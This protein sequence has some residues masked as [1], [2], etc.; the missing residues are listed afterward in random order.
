MVARC[1][2]RNLSLGFAPHSGEYP[3]ESDHHR[4]NYPEAG[5]RYSDQFEDDGHAFLISSRW[6]S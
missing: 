5:Y 4:R 2:G 3:G 1:P 6:L